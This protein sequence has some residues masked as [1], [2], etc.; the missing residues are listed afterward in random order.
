MIK[1]W[2]KRFAIFLIVIGILYGIGR[3]IDVMYG[4]YQFVTRAPYQQLPTPHSMLIKWQS[5]AKSIGCIE[6]NATHS[7]CETTATQK[8]AIDVTGLHEATTYPFKVLEDGTPIDDANRSLTTLR[9]KSAPLR[10]WVIGDSGQPGIHQQNVLNAAKPLFKNR[11]PNLWLLLGDNAYRS[12]TQDQYNL[13]LFTP[14]ASLVSHLPP[15]AVNGNHDD[16]R[17]AYSMIF[18][19]PTLGQ[20]AMP[21]SHSDEFYAINDGDLHLIILDSQQGDLGAN[22]NMAQWLKADLRTNQKKWVIVAFHHPPYSD[23]GHKSDNAF[24]SHG[25]M[26]DIRENILP[27]FEAYNVDLVLSG[28]SHG[29][30]RSKLLHGHYGTSDTFDPDSHIIDNAAHYYK[31][32]SQGAIYCVMGSSSKLDQATYK[33]PALR[34]SYALMGSMVIDI[35]KTSLKAAFITEKG[36]IKDDFR[37]DKE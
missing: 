37:I 12:G 34:F 2:L 11:Y 33:H 1:K 16:R 10:I 9:T 3:T 21:A 17:F 32:K 29:Y 5:S 26:R 6:L 35:N 22:G 13:G 30:E 25:K 20:S 23:G 14:Y 8:H 15:I 31:K 18:D 28:H 4:S 7:Y 19:A 27:I 36:A 24:D